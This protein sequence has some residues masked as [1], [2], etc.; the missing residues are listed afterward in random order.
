MQV[1]DI[2]NLTAFPRAT[3]AKESG[4]RFESAGGPRPAAAQGRT[5][6]AAALAAGGAECMAA[7]ELDSTA[8]DGR[9]ALLYRGGHTKPQVYFQDLSG[10]WFFIASTVS[11]RHL[12]PCFLGHFSPVLR[13]LFAVLSRFPASWR[14]DGE[15]GRKMA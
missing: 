11:Q 7:F 12:P 15:N 5:A 14:Q 4:A 13:R 3:F 2:A 9:L 10:T 8:L 6:A 1:N